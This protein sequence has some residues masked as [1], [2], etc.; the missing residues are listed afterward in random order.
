MTAVE[1][2]ERMGYDYSTW[3][4]E[5][6][7]AGA[8]SVEISGNFDVRQIPESALTETRPS[9]PV[10]KRTKSKSSKKSGAR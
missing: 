3:L 8:R 9:R 4:K 7:V 6:I 5:G 2:A 1:F 10:R